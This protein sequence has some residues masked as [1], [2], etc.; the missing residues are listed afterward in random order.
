MLPS[1]L[2]LFTQRTPEYVR[3]HTVRTGDASREQAWR[4][5]IE[6]TVQRLSCTQQNTIE[7]LNDMKQ[8]LTRISTGS[9]IQSQSKSAT[10]FSEEESPNL[11]L[12]EQRLPDIRSTPSVI[13]AIHE[14]AMRQDH[15][16]SPSSTL[17]S[18]GAEATLLR[19]GDVPSV[20]PSELPTSSDKT[21]PAEPS[22][23]Y[24]DDDLQFPSNTF[25][26]DPDFMTQPPAKATRSQK[27][28][29]QKRA[30]VPK[31]Y[32]KSRGPL[33][34]VPPVACPS[35]GRINPRGR[36]DHPVACNKPVWILHPDV[37]GLPVAYG[38]SGISWKSTRK[39]QLY[40]PC[41]LGQQMVQVHHVYN[42]SATLMFLEL[43]RQPFRSL[44]EAVVPQ[45]SSTV[46]VKWA[47]HLLVRD[48]GAEE[49]A[50][51]KP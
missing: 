23:V 36:T 18:S 1:R 25:S 42:S 35:I 14:T 17:D 43:E 51:S 32:L 38:R 4:S 37:P 6:A 24:P 21:K 12:P 19:H 33:H 16:A 47:H 7:V 29:T 28:S 11:T 26:D 49:H 20:N 27:C 46:Y 8:L 44:I 50:V 3:Q 15:I 9:F 34:H 2:S 48:L 31:K 13:A 45:G 22:E 40:T 5:N 30:N 39:N 10:P 41:D